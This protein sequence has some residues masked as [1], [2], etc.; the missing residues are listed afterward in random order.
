[1]IAA[2]CGVFYLFFAS[3]HAIKGSFY[4]DQAKLK[5]FVITITLMINSLI[6]PMFKTAFYLVSSWFIFALCSLSI[7]APISTLQ[8]ENQTHYAWGFGFTP[9]Y[10]ENQPFDYVDPL[11][12]KGGELRLPNLYRTTSFDSFNPFILKGIAATYLTDLVFESLATTSADESGAIYGLLAEKIIV[13]PAITQV[14][15]ELRPEAK[16]SNGDAVLASDVLFSY[17]TLMSSAA[18]PSYRSIFSEVANVVVE[19][20]RRIRFEFKSRNPDMVLTVAGLP[21]FS[22]KWLGNRSLADISLDKPIAT[23]PYSIASF[24]PGK[25]IVY[26]R[27]KDYWGWHLSNRKGMFNFD[28]IRVS[29]YKDD[30]AKL[31]AFK[32]GAFDYIMEMRAKNWARFYQGRLFDQ[33]LLHKQA[34]THQNVQ[35]MQGF[36]INTRRPQFQDVRVRQALGLA[37]DFDWL[38]RQL[39]YNSYVPS[40]SFWNNSELSAIQA[41]S[42]QNMPDVNEL[43]LLRSL[44]QRF[45]NQLPSGIWGPAP[46][47]PSTNAP[48]SLRQNL[49]K[50][51][52][53]FAQAGWHYKNGQLRNTAGDVFR[54]EFLEDSGG[55]GSFARIMSPL[56]KNLRQVGIEVS[57]RIVDFS[58]YQ[59]RLE[60]FDFDV[61][62]L[63]MSASMNPGNELR[64]AWGSAAAKTTGSDNLAGVQ[65]PV[66]DALIQA[67]IQ[68]N[69][70]QELI[71]ATRALDRVLLHSYYVIPQWTNRVHRIGY[72][73]RIKPPSKLPK[74]YRAET[75][76]LWHW[77]INIDL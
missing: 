27:R 14:I 26:Q 59:K 38:N 57:E 33:G 48:G 10:Q 34:F 55:A 64:D 35:G 43:T 37:L 68:S 5:A 3:Y 75:W 65:S 20:E 39:F 18:N 28:R 70:R 50:A 22:K 25:N 46:N 77:S 63:V 31:E 45:P 30:L 36:V 17:Q 44:D 53:L 71:T 73:S 41:P 15:F 54:L 56:M 61:V 66:I 4:T 74:Y 67:I 32:S 6:I 42:G 69:N 12:P 76:P 49:K 23:G 52:E 62:S 60:N 29:Y 40:S 58:L 24:D 11:V 7:A 47:Y 13:N 8:K 21:I 9:K 16:F 51:R 72:H 19:G 2:V 1:M